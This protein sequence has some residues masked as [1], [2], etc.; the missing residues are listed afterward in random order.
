ML[1]RVHFVLAIL[2]ELLFGIGEILSGIIHKIFFGIVLGIV[3]MVRT[4]ASVLSGRL[5]LASDTVPRTC[6]RN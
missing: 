1:A 5:G 3:D 4:A 2:H 6:N